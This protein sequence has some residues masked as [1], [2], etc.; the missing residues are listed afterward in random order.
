MLRQSLNEWRRRH[1]SPKCPVHRWNKVRQR[2]SYIIAPGLDISFNS[3]PVG[4]RDHTGGEQTIRLFHIKLN[5][6]V[7]WKYPKDSD[8]SIDKVE[9]WIHLYS[10]GGFEHTTVEFPIRPITSIIKY[11]DLSKDQLLTYE[12]KAGLA[13]ILKVCDKRI[14]YER[15]KNIEL[16]DA[17]KKIFEERFKD[18]ILKNRILT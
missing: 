7:I 10:R 15:L 9:L 3:S 11:L 13:D 4:Y 1:S 8:K 18:K 14:G 5:C 12:D 2:L 6:E 16:S 17:A